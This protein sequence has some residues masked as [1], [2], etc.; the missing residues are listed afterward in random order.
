M[1]SLL[2]IPAND[3]DARRQDV[4]AAQQLLDPLGGVERVDQPGVVVVERAGRHAPEPA[5]ELVELHVG[6]GRAHLAGDDD[7]RQRSDPVDAVG[8]AE[9][10]PVGRL[11]VRPR[12]DGLA[13]VVLV[14]PRVDPVGE[15]PAVGV[16]DPQPAVVVVDVA[17]RGRRGP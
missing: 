5:P 11:E 13:Q 6:A 12:L 4:R 15:Q 1:P 10:L 17:R 9:R 16:H 8:V 14:G 3:A 7:P 2:L